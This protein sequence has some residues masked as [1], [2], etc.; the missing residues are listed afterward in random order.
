VQSVEY[1]P[2]FRNNMSPQYLGSRAPLF[3][4][5]HSD[6]LLGLFFDAEDGGDKFL[7]NVS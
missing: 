1:P 3:A 5:F 6:F 4:C 2:M 7:R